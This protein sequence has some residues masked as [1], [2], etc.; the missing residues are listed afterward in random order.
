MKMKAQQSKTYGMQKVVLRQFIAIQSY[1]KK[2]ENL[3]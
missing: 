2:Q 3:K 1:L